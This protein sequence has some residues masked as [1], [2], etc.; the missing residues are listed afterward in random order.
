VWKFEGSHPDLG[1]RAEDLHGEG[2]QKTKNRS[3]KDRLDKS[4]AS[5]FTNVGLWKTE[6]GSSFVGGAIAREEPTMVKEEANYKR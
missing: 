6:R 1:R 2:C 3:A 4:I 5:V